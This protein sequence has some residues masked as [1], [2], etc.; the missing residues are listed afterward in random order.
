DCPMT[1]IWPAM[2]LLLFLIPLL[3]LRYLMLN[4]KRQQ[5]A[6]RF[7][8]LW[9]GQKFS[10]RQFNARRHL[11]MT[12]FLLALTLLIIGLARPQAIVSIPRL[13]GTVI[14]TFDVSGSMA[15]D[16]MKPTRM[17]AAKAAA[18]AFIAKQPVNVLIGIVAFSDSGLSVQPPTIDRDAL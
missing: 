8:N 11:P 18:Q 1:F 14:L 15:A 16:D 12:F 6:E 3:V 10:G 2:L 5:I 7:G 4:R 13:G 17:D 9:L